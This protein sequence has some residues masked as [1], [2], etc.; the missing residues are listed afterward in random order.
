MTTKFKSSNDILK[1]IEKDIIDHQIKTTPRHNN[2]I[3]LRPLIY[4]CIRE[5]YFE[6]FDCERI[7]PSNLDFYKSF[8]WTAPI[9]SALHEKIQSLLGLEDQEYTE[10]L[11]TFNSFA[12]TLFVRS[13]CD[14][15]DLRDPKNIILYEFKTK[16][17]IPKEP[18][19]EELLQNLLS[20]FFFRKEYKVDIKGSSMVYINRKNPDEIKFFN[21]DF[22]DKESLVYLDIIDELHDT[23]EK[24]QEILDY[25]KKGVPPTMQSKYIKTIAY[26]K[27]KC[28]DC[29]YR[30]ICKALP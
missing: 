12:P 2:S 20:V 25:M 15:I 21:Y 1:Y 29:P 18:Y 3:S 14:G 7:P 30:D 16:D 27:S 22:F 10:K 5:V 13:K 4:N 23:F 28:L 26:G 6:I 17:K 11:M 9:G 8:Y 24:I 19:H